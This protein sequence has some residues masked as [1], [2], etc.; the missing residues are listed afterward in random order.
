MSIPMVW[1][2]IIKR[3]PA[4]SGWSTVVVGLITSWW[5]RY[6]VEAETIARLVGIDGELSKDENEYLVILSGIIAIV[7][8]SSVW[9]LLTMYFDRFSPPHYRKKVDEFFKRMNTPVNFQ[10]EMGKDKDNLQLRTLGILCLVYGGFIVLM[11]AI[12]ND[13][14][15]RLCF[16]FC[17]GTLCLIGTLLYR[18]S[19]SKKTPSSSSPS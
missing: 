5:L 3:A 8:V 4:W 11:G 16:A 2:I 7:S 12:P 15:G 19:R 14:T 18:S 6:H 17:G 10:E 13:F 9:F 1:S